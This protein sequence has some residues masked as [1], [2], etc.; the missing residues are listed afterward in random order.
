MCSFCVKR[1]TPHAGMEGDQ[2]GLGV[3]KP[4]EQL[5]PCNHRLVAG[6]HIVSMCRLLQEWSDQAERLPQAPSE[7]PWP[8]IDGG[9]TVGAIERA[10]PHDARLQV[11]A[12]RGDGGHPA[13][14][15]GLLQAQ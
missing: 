12:G 13:V 5:E 9:K 1:F 14:C 6:S 7:P 3:Q 4:K 8:H 15:P 10:Y 11:L 2:I